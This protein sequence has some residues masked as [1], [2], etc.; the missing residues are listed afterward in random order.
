MLDTREGPVLTLYVRRLVSNGILYSSVH[1]Y[2]TIY[3]VRRQ[4]ATRLA[5]V[6]TGELGP[7]TERG[8]RHDGYSLDPN[9]STLVP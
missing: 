9:N 8:L 6:G 4:V 5:V 2:K 3:L 1:Q 7:W